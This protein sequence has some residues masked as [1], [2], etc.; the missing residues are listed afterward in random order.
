MATLS[1]FLLSITGSIAARALFSLGFGL[2]SY[3]ALAAL[4]STVI[5]NAQGLYGSIGS[6]IL[7]YLNFGGIGAFMGIIS[8]AMLTRAALLAVKKL[9]PV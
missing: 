4:T 6:T 3:V 8:A 5:S 2:F 7:Q 9:R 1:V